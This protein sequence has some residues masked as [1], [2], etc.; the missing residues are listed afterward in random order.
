V[1]SL[2]YLGAPECGRYDVKRRPIP[3][4]QKIDVWSIGCVLS[5]AATWVLSGFS[6]IRKFEECLKMAVRDNSTNDHR[7]TPSFHNGRNVLSDVTR[8]HNVMR[9]KIRSNDYI[10]SGILDLI[11]DHLLQ[12]DPKA[13][14]DSKELCEYLDH[15]LLHE[16]KPPCAPKILAPLER[17]MYIETIVAEFSGRK[18]LLRGIEKTFQL[19]TTGQPSPSSP[20]VLHDMG[21]I[22]KTHIAREDVCT[23]PPSF[24][25]PR[26]RHSNTQVDMTLEPASTT[27]FNLRDSN[28]RRETNS[29]RKR[30]RS[31]SLSF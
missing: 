27:T 19:G 28:T 2:T 21:G 12:G 14:F 9:C 20:L 16:Q 8:W 7:N 25:S 22:G 17:Q 3:V 5:I 18:P 6:G 11:D 31:V 24:R 30:R 26:A 15:L 23:C 29:L 4:S 10:T 1:Q 13:R